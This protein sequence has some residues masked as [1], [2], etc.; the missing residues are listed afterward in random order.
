MERLSIVVIVG[1]V[2]LV[3]ALALRGA[4]INRYVR[5]RLLVSSV[6][7]AA[8]ATAAALADYAPL[9]PDLAR[10]IRLVAPLLVTFGLVN[11]VVAVAINPWRADRI[12]DR[13]PKIVQ[14]TVII[15]LFAL[16]AILILREKIL[17]T[18]AVSA[19]VIGF[20]LQDTLGNLFAGLAIQ[21]EKPFRVGHWVSLAGK[22]GLVS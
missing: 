7:F 4:T 20:A 21:I 2:L 11:A 1:F 3:V 15:A 6:L 12:P 16:V 9:S 18:T 13:F 14:D 5:G 19:V 8:Y 10:Q 22:D 17:A